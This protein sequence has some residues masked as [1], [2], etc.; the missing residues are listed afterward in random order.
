[1]FGKKKDKKDIEK[2]LL[3]NF[4][5]CIVLASFK[6]SDK[7][8]TYVNGNMFDIALFFKEL[9]TQSKDVRNIA[10]ASIQTLKLLEELNKDK[11][12]SKKEE[13]KKE[14]KEKSQPKAKKGK[15]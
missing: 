2:I 13:A 12:E 10:E 14:E 15:K 4:D 5:K 7:A 6:N 11:K 9:F 3:D 8:I 1:M